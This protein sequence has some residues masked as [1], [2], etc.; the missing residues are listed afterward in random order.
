MFHPYMYPCMAACAACVQADAPRMD[1]EGM[2]DGEL[3]GSTIVRVSRLHPK[4]LA[5]LQDDELLA[6]WTRE[7]R[8]RV[9]ACACAWAPELCREGVQVWAVQ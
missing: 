1:D 5:Q 6:A 7:V 3:H 4:V 2:D 8:A 9:C